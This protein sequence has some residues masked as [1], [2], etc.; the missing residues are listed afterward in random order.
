M[1]VNSLMDCSSEI[2]TGK[3][4]RNSGM[5]S[6]DFNRPLLK[7]GK[8]VTQRMFNSSSYLIPDVKRE[9]L[10]I[11]GRIR[12]CRQYECHHV[13]LSEEN[14]G[15]VI[16][17]LPYLLGLAS[18][19]GR[20]P[21]SQMDLQN[22][23]L[24][25]ST[26]SCIQQK[27]QNLL[28]SQ[29]A[30]GSPPYLQKQGLLIA[31]EVGKGA[32]YQ[33]LGV[34][35]TNIAKRM[36][37]P[38]GSYDIILCSSESYKQ[39]PDMDFAIVIVDENCAHSSTFSDKRI[40]NKFKAS[41]HIFI[42]RHFTPTKILQTNKKEY[43]L[44]LLAYYSS[45]IT[46]QRI[47]PFVSQAHLNALH[48]VK[49]RLQDLRCNHIPIV[50]NMATE[51][52]MHEMICSLPYM[53]G[54]VAYHTSQCLDLTKP[55]LIIATDLEAW[56]TLRTVMCYHSEPYLVSIGMMKRSEYAQGAHYSWHRI[57]DLY[58]V[59]TY[60]RQIHN[61]EV[62]LLNADGS[63][64]DGNNYVHITTDY[65]K[66]L[67]LNQFSAIIIFENEHITT[68]REQDIICRFAGVPMILFRVN[69]CESAGKK[70]VQ[71]ETKLAT[72]QHYSADTILP[73]LLEHNHDD[74]TEKYM[75]GRLSVLTEYQKIGLVS[76]VDWIVSNQSL[77]QVA[78]VN[79]ALGYEKSGMLIWCLPSLLEWAHTNHLIPSGSFNLHK[80]MLILYNNEESY[81]MLYS[82]FHS[83]PSF[84]Q[85]VMFSRDPS[86][87]RSY[88]VQD[89]TSASKLSALKN[90]YKL[91][92]SDFKFLQWLPSDC[93][94]AVVVYSSSHE[95]FMPEKKQASIKKKF[96]EIGRVIFFEAYKSAPG[97]P[98]PF[99]LL[100]ETENYNILHTVRQIA[101]NKTKPNGMDKRNLEKREPLQLKQT[102]EPN[103]KPSENRTPQKTSSPSLFIPT[104]ACTAKNTH[105]SKS[106][107]NG[108][109]PK[110]V[111]KNF[112]T[113]NS[114]ELVK[115]ETEK[116]SESVKLQEPTKS[117]KTTE[118]AK[119][120]VETL[121][122]HPLI[123][124]KTENSNKRSVHFK[125]S[126]E[127]INT[128][129]RA[130]KIVQ[131][132]KKKKTQI[133]NGQNLYHD[134]HL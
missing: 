36:L 25:I 31:S 60:C 93:F 87:C 9:L 70:T 72:V 83:H 107:N 28:Q 117:S 6:Q 133:N 2:T 29:P 78:Y 33:T 42:F 129:S 51:T 116:S 20:I 118:P 104:S 56:S 126:E 100:S 92:F 71:V 61:Q 122:S 39:I 40:R 55:V 11:E 111:E 106:I 15:T 121:I 123:E 27:L 79:S 132:S 73:K 47:S 44:P 86:R 48:Q 7:W 85:T 131:W 103:I 8:I 64:L 17:C 90:D 109:L 59:Y 49:K 82:L 74:I 97:P 32:Y 80:P 75:L 91:I 13:Y 21:Q 23:I 53:L 10:A 108:I 65:F 120:Q 1:L 76:M 114:E 98:V 115:P 88:L 84:H 14:T 81:K 52:G 4:S 12:G 68:E 99:L 63:Y 96:I 124:A 94:S 67:P 22:P 58:D 3:I 113:K 54:E 19:V 24:V 105:K 43:P 128:E 50:I 119:V 95:H 66:D 37:H 5:S 46:I 38:Y 112:Q 102:N 16:S 45:I 41:N 125:L 101:Y 30:D 130:K 35:T 110:K 34:V 134:Q 26:C 57:Q 18:I 127:N 89:P 62:V 69:W 77:R